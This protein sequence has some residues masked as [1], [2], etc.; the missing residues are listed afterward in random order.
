MSQ[1]TKL[2]RYLD[3][4]CLGTEVLTFDEIYTIC[5]AYVDDSFMQH[6]YEL[7]TY[8]LSVMKIDLRSRTVLFSRN[9]SKLKYRR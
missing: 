8:G 4:C 5:G 7:E 9:A 2:W 6:K 1:Y 3:D